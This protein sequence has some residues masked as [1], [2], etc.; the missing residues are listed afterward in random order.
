[1]ALEPS[2]QRCKRCDDIQ[3][4]QSAIDRRLI[5]SV[6]SKVVCCSWRRPPRCCMKY[7]PNTNSPAVWIGTRS[8]DEE[9]CTDNPTTC[10][11]H[12]DRPEWGRESTKLS[13]LYS[14][15]VYTIV[16]LCV[17]LSVC[18][19]VSIERPHMNNLHVWRWPPSI[20]CS[21]PGGT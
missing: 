11:P 15:C 16:M 3:I 12:K 18:L 6:G 17:Y 14:S 8:R 9:N 20:S 7:Q 1:M 21:Y 4:D 19:S 5:T 13:S 10:I 2:R